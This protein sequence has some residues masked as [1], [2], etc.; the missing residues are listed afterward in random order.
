MPGI[1]WVDVAESADDEAIGISTEP[2]G[3]LLLSSVTAQFPGTTG[4]KFK[5]EE[6]GSFRGV[7]CQDNSLFAPSEEEGWGKTV[8]ICVKPKSAR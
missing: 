4:L 2:D 1:E 6:S 7:R 8:Y 5:H 3:T